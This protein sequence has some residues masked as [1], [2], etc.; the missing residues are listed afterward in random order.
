MPRIQYTVDIVPRFFYA[1]FCTEFNRRN[2]GR[3]KHTEPVILLMIK[4]FFSRC[5]VVLSLPLTVILFF[6]VSFPMYGQDEPLTGSVFFDEADTVAVKNGDSYAVPKMVDLGLSVMWAE[7]NLGASSPYE[8]GDFFAW[9][10]TSSYQPE[11]YIKKNYLHSAD[12]NG[13]AVDFSEIGHPASELMSSKIFHRLNSEYDAGKVNL[14]GGWRMPTAAE[15]EELRTRC[16]FMMQKDGN[17]RYIRATGPNGNSV[18]FIITPGYVSGK[19]DIKSKREGK[20][21]TGTYWSSDSKDGKGVTFILTDFGRYA[22]G[23]SN[24]WVGYQV[25]PVYDVKLAAS[26]GISL[27]TTDESNSNFTSLASIATQ[28]TRNE[29]DSGKLTVDW[30]DLPRE[31]TTRTMKLKIGINS[32]STI[33]ATALFVNGQLTRGIKAVSNDGYDMV[34]TPTVNLAEGIN[35]LRL[36]IMNGSG[37]TVE[38][39][40]VIYYSDIKD[41][42]ANSLPQKPLTKPQEKRVALVVGNSNY[43]GAELANPGNDA[44][45]LADKLRSLGFDVMLVIDADKRHLEDNIS[46]FADKASGSDVAMFFFAGHGLQYNGS[47]YLVPVDAVLRSARDVVYET[48]D[49]NR[50]LANMEDSGCKVNILALD[51]CRNNPF[52]RKWRHRGTEQ[53]TRGLSTINAPVGSFIS[54]AT[55]PGNVANDGEGRNSPYTSALLKV[56]DEPGLTIENVFKQVTAEVYRSTKTAQT[57]WYSSSLFQGDF[58]FNLPK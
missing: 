18:F 23:S 35:T 17:N 34:L 53:H 25:R 52:E 56:L 9:G 43:P 36:E 4:R 49:V 21:G 42:Q 40:P 51:A 50:V 14:G 41:M 54:Y 37:K 24:P 48:T 46:E 47:N 15:W 30:V 57:P 6:V 10:E 26:K 7:S 44:H 5:K 2:R 8:I 33:K 39:M 19:N 31:T 16:T 20:R 11:Q 13:E 58:Y 27:P 3:T 12:G 28:G 32:S 55:A 38:E 29:K 1:I 22:L 45:D